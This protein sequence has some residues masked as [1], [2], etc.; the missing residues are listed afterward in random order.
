MPADRIVQS[1]RQEVT[2]MGGRKDHPDGM[3]PAPPPPIT[4]FSTGITLVGHLSGRVS[5]PDRVFEKK[6]R[7]LAPRVFR[8]FFTLHRGQ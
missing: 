4:R 8:S 3:P 2:S 5:L 7:F 6:R 1:H